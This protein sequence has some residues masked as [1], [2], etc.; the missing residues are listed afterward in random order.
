[1]KKLKRF[2]LVIFLLVVLLVMMLVKW[3]YGYREE[4]NMDKPPIISPWPTIVVKKD[5]MDFEL[6]E[7]LPY[8]GTGFVVEKYVGPKTLE[9][10]IKGV[11]KK[12]VEK[13]VFEWLIEQNV[14]TESY[15]LVFQ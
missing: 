12:I 13:K 15:K 4:E 9:V 8:R 1:M 14:A 2:Q 11:D 5:E 3:K 7:Q 6:W 10:T